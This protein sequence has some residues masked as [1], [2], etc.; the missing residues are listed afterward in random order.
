MH[1]CGEESQEQQEHCEGTQ[2]EIRGLIDWIK[3]EIRVTLWRR[4][5]STRL[6]V[7]TKME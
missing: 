7:W 1:K 3:Q 5:L 2:D 6:E 4:R